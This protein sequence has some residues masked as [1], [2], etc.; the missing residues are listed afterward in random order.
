MKNSEEFLTIVIPTLNEE[1]YLPK[2]LKDL[3]DQTYRNFEIIIVDAMSEDKTIEK[4]K[5]IKKYYPLTI[6]TSKKKNVCF[7]RNLGA[8]HAKS[9]WIIFM[10]A[11]NRLPKYFLQGIKY[12]VE[13][14][15][16]DFFTTYIKPDTNHQLDK[17]IA[18]IVNL[19]F[20][21]Q[22]NTKKPSA[23]ESLLGCKKTAFNK[24]G[25][26]N[27]NIKWA[28][29]VDLLA[30]AKKKHFKFQ[31][32]KNPIYTYSFRRLRSQG[33]IKMTRNTA[34]LFLNQI[35]NKPLTDKKI[36]QLYPM[37][38][39]AFFDMIQKPKPY[40][41]NIL[42]EIFNLSPKQFLQRISAKNKPSLTE[43][44]ENLFKK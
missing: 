17:G 26:F 6:I 11:D 19:Y 23:M 32:Y 2:L 21:A 10:D 18:K 7:Q 25:G 8:K 29:G 14:T 24:V 12:R 5:K 39:G 1:E 30:T 37:K 22:K 31:V 28:E 13:K 35:F 40:P 38:G 41:E 4:A 33:K 9:D 3:I 36:S 16:P 42:I 44:V 34:K 15:N 20:E 43:R 27:T